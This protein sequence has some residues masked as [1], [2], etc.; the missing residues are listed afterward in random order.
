MEKT[1]HDP[2]VRMR[3]MAN[4]KTS[5][6]IDVGLSAKAELKA[7]VPASAVGRLVDALT[8]AIRPFT[9]ARGLKA[10]VIRLQREDVLIEI[11]K[12]ARRRLEIEGAEIHPIPIKT[13]VPLLEKASLEDPDDD[14]MLERWA[15]L[16][17]AEASDPGEN[18]R[19]Y[20]DTLASIDSWQA[21]LLETIAKAAPGRDFFRVE[22]FTRQFATEAF[23]Q[24]INR[25]SG[26]KN[27]EILATLE[28]IPGYTFFFDGANIPN[29]EEFE[30]KDLQE[31]PALLHLDALGLVWV[32]ATSF[33]GESERHF[34]LNAQLTPLGFQFVALFSKEDDN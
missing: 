34:V 12:R 22:H 9:E 30:F 8:D 1:R 16:L 32:H 19:W 3:Q 14:E 28:Q 5:V 18:R 31:V 21:R 10:D 27:S 4:D 2:V 11:S 29:T 20:I 13:L 25:A 7:E 24:D 33:V 26:A 17:A 23:A 15:T 6:N